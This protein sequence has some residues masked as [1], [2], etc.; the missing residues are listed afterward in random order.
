LPRVDPKPEV[1]PPEWWSED[2]YDEDED[3]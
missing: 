3:Y 2:D 1:E